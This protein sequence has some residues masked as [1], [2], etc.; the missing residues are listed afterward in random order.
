MVI[1]MLVDLPKNNIFSHKDLT[2]F[3]GGG[4]FHHLMVKQNPM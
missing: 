1:N 3:W 4:D 2:F